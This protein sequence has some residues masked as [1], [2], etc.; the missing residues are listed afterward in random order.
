MKFL[1]LCGAYGSSDVRYARAL[2]IPPCADNFMQKFRV[3]LGMLTLS[4]F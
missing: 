3:Q 2:Y 4:T 1:C